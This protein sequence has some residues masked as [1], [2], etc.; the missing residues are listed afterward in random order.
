MSKIFITGGAGYVGAVL[1]PYLVSKGH[2]V[3]VFDL[4]IYG[5][6]VLPKNENHGPHSHL[7]SPILRN[8]VPPA[9]LG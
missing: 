3:T 2:Q 5:E 8:S 6:N 1:A 9:D 7:F 4:M